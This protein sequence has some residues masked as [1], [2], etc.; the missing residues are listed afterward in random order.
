MVQKNGA[1]VGG[2]PEVRLLERIGLRAFSG[3]IRYEL[4][5]QSEPG[6]PS[7]SALK[8]ALDGSK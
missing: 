3:R 2:C 4:V 8:R 6:H 7:T 1:R 5:R